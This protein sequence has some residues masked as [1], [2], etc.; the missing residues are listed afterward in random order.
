MR[1]NCGC[2]WMSRKHSLS[3]SALDSSSRNYP[4]ATSSYCLPVR[5]QS[6]VRDLGNSGQS[7]ND[8]WS[9]HDCLPCWLLPAAPTRS[10]QIQLLTPTVAQTLVQAFI[11][12]RLDYC[13]LLL[14][15]NA[16]SQL[17]QLAYSPSRTRQHVWSLVRGV[18]TTSRQ[19]CW[20]DRFTGY[21]S[22]NGFS[23]SWR[24]WFTSAS[25]GVQMTAAWSGRR[26]GLRSSSSATK[27]EVLPTR[28]TF[29]D[30]SFAVDGPHVWNSLP[31]SIRDP[32][33]T[34][35]DSRHICLNSSCGVCD[36]EQTPL[37]VLTI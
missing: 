22:G 25:M 9:R 23:S 21:R 12:C 19:F 32:S 8:G 18:R 17:R 28:T 4:P 20:S 37:N 26:S 27:L 2:D 10:D 34:L 6:V 13:N 36:S 31:A 11:S 24:Y 30:W 7:A 3:G 29:G 33:L 5:P 14:D 1:A 16:D 35:A 15:G